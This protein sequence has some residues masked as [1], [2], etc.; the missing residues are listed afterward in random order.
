MQGKGSLLLV[1]DFL[2]DFDI[3]L[4]LNYQKLN[5]ANET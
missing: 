1:G 3:I 5:E 4:V 2:K